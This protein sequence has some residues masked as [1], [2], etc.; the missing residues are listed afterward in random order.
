MSLNNPEKG[1]LRIILN[2]YY[3]LIPPRGVPPL[4]VCGKGKKR[5]RVLSHTTSL[6]SGSFE[7]ARPIIST[8]QK[9]II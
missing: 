4:I 7:G 6:E 2:K 9:R 3:L 5:R 1:W 8:K